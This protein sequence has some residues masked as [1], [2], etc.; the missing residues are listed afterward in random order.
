[1]PPVVILKTLI[2]L[3]RTFCLPKGFLN[4]VLLFNCQCVH[5]DLAARN[6]LVSEDYVMKIGDFGLARDIY[7][8]KEYVKTTNGLLPVKWMALESL[9]DRVYTEKS[10]V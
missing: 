7:T 6:I 1:M 9:F 2:W 8:N 10:D 3:K 4:V 5:R